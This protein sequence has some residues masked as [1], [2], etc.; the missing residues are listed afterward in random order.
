MRV[1]TYPATIIDELQR[2]ILEAARL[3]RQ[4]RRIYLTADEFAELIET[5]LVSGDSEKLLASGYT[6]YRGYEVVREGFDEA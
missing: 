2:A 4:I 5:H 3:G 1:T 6:K